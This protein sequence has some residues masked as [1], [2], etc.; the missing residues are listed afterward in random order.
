MAGVK[1]EGS[2]FG[3]KWDEVTEGWRKLLNEALH[4]SYFSFIGKWDIQHAWSV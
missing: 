3:S 1:E 4:D 2:V